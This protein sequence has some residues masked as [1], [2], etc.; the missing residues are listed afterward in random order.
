MEKQE[1]NLEISTHVVRYIYFALICGF[2]FLI[3]FGIKELR[4][5]IAISFLLAFL[6]TPAVDL[7]EGLG[8]NRHFGVILVLAILFLGIYLLVYLIVPLIEQ[9]ISNIISQ[10]D[11]I[12]TAAA[13]LITNTREYTRRFL[14]S[15]VNIDELNFDNLIGLFLKNMESASGGIIEVLPHLLTYAIITMIILFI[16]LLEGDSIYTNLMDLVPNTFFEMAI[17]ITSNIKVQIAGYLRGI[18]IQWGI[19][20]SVMGGGYMIIGLPYAPI[21]GFVAATLNLIPYVGPVA[22]IVPAVIV[23]LLNPGGLLVIK[24]ITIFGIA[25]IIDN[26]YIQP[27]ILARSVQLHP[28]LAVLTFISFQYFFGIIGMVIAVPATGVLLVSLRTM[29]KSLKAF[30]II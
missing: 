22:G 16:F 17:L 20:F 18:A 3:L 27:V 2:I 30:R 25:H 29:H 7:F 23:A 28:L 15:F 4:A 8:I 10:S 5:P 9:D 1:Q 24:I 11:T 19:I 12:K 21:L 26:A 6:L 14:P 13:D